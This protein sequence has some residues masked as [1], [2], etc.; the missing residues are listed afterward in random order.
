[1]LK[2]A[3]KLRDATVLRC[4]GMLLQT[5]QDA[6][7]EWL[8]ITYIDEDGADV[9][10]TF[11]LHSPAQRHL[12]EQQF[13]RLHSR[14]PGIPFS[15]QSASDIIAQQALLRHPD[16][17]VAHRQKAFWKIRHKVFDYQGRFRRA[18]SAS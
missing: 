10:E 1:M 2:A 17:V 15:W 4:S 11:R 8:R 16:F 18:D 5:G 7:G 9:P 12:F 6:K 14:A 3:L 13:L